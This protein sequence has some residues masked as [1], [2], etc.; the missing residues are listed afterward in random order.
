MTHP[1]IEETATNLLEDAVKAVWAQAADVADLARTEA[2]RVLLDAYRQAYPDAGS[3]QI[4]EFALQQALRRLGWRSS[5]VVSWEDAAHRL[6]RAAR[7][8]VSERVHLC[9]LDWAGA[10]PPFAY[11]PNA[12]RTF[13]PDELASLITDA[14]ASP[15]DAL[16]G[17]DL[18]A[19][20]QFRWLV[21]RETAPVPAA[22]GARALPVLFNMSEDYGRIDPYRRRF[23]AAVERALFCLLA[24]S[25]E[26]MTR[27]SS[28]DWRPFQIPWIY[29]VDDDLFARRPSPPDAATL[30]WT[31]RYYDHG[32]GDVEEVE[33]PLE[34]HLDDFENALT[35]LDEEAWRRFERAETSA[36]L[37]APV[38]HFF[39]AGLQA[40][41][42]D[43]FLAHVATIEASLGQASD[44]IRK[45][46]KPLPNGGN[47]GTART[48][49]RLG[50]LLDDP[51]AGDTFLRLFKLR[52][53]Y[54]HGE[55]IGAVSGADRSTARRLA[56]RCVCALVSAASEDPAP[57]DRASWLKS[58]ISELPVPTRQPNGE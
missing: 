44:H 27:E 21:V 11:G 18:S 2:F 35:W 49:W 9:P 45:G 28:A 47:G 7:T 42:I 20:A 58:L 48:A 53:Q 15:V 16:T 52:S 4:V 26:D 57:Q 33:T 31:W 40:D 51:P 37:T 19:L 46:Q 1:V 3:R 23:P 36:L 5:A 38:I 55:L 39:I 30:T 29:T 10:I 43:E 32:D 34:I 6:D 8:T 56:R 24:M 50:R 54:V 41:G 12:I 13:T 14:A 22:A 25:W 17:L